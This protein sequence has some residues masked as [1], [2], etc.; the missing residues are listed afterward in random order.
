MGGFLTLTP[1]L[2]TWYKVLLISVISQCSYALTNQN[3]V[4]RF[5]PFKDLQRFVLAS[6]TSSINCIVLYVSDF[7]KVC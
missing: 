1:S 3:W 7:T 4:V 2:A 5:T 6:I